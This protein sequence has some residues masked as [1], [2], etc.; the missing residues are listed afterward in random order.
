[1]RVTKVTFSATYCVANSFWIKPGLEANL[2]MQ[3]DINWDAEKNQPIES[4]LYPEDP[5][6][7]LDHLKNI[8]EDWVKANYPGA[9]LSGE[10]EEIGVND[11]ISYRGIKH[12]NNLNA[13]DLSSPGE[14]PKPDAKTIEDY[15]NGGEKRRLMIE[16]VYDMSDVK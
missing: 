14:K 5:T 9:Q 6:K 4:G 7:C 11:P 3:S 15:K 16:S 1:M 13:Y 8:I 12:S 10:A 2:G